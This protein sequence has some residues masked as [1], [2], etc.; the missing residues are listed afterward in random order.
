MIID[1]LPLEEVFPG[2]NHHQETGAI[3]Q[4]DILREEDGIITEMT[5]MVIKAITME[6]NR[7]EQVPTDIV[8]IKII[9]MRA[10]ITGRAIVIIEG[11]QI[12][13]TK[14]NHIITNLKVEIDTT[15]ETK[16]RKILQ[17][18]P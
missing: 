3:L 14:I 13:E 6:A 11:D 8:I 12:A 10:S 15:T 18:Q 2:Q 7:Q 5:S 9:M 17:L 16:L 1:V 4:K